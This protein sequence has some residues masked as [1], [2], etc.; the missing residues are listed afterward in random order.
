MHGVAT[1]TIRARVRTYGSCPTY[2]HGE[3]RDHAGYAP[4]E[5]PRAPAASNR[6][7]PA[8]RHPTTPSRLR[9]LGPRSPRRGRPAKPN[10]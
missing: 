1:A 8:P 4:P 10:L 3:L 2:G 5:R 6:C 9:A 7:P